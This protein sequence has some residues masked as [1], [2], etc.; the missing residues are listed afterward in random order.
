[1][2][3]QTLTRSSRLEQTAG[4][5]TA[6][7]L[8]ARSDSNALFDW[9]SR[10]ATDRLAMSEAL[11]PLAGLPVYREL[12]DEQRWRLAMLEAA[13]FFSLN[14]AG[15]RELMSGLAQRLCGDRPA[16]ISNYLQHFIDE[17]NAHTAVFARFCLDYGGGIFPDRQVR[18]PREFAP[19]EE[20]FLFF[21]RVLIF[22]EVAHFHNKAIANDPGVWPLA[23]EINRY[24]AEDESRHIAFGRLQLGELWECFAPQWGEDG[25]RRIGRYLSHYTAVTL[26]SYV[27]PDVY[28][29]IGLPAGVRQAILESRHWNSIAVRST[30]R[31]TRW[32]RKYFDFTSSSVCTFTLRRAFVATSFSS[33]GFTRAS[34]WPGSARTR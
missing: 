19:G 4:R 3:E 20:E 17:E 29:A 33:S 21:G 24:H 32:L 27:N 22:E 25:R 1:M 14:I 15:E 9:P 2:T 34:A 7:S 18:F 30:D 12:S 16:S 8:V 11:L 6:L 26:R 5:L 23:R 13:N 28:R 31:I 10:A